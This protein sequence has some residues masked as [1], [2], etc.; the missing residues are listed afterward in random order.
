MAGNNLGLRERFDRLTMPEPNSG[1][2]LW[3]GKT[4]T[5]VRGDNYGMIRDNGVYRQATHVALELA[6]RPLL[7]G[8]I[9]LHHCD[10]GYCVNE[11]HLFGGT[12]RDN[13]LD[14]VRKGRHGS[15][16]KTH[17]PKGH[18]YTPENTR[19]VNDGRRTYRKCRACGR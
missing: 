14:A 13:S 17:C 18:E 5:G 11:V 8:Q 6:N 10:N 1:C 4:G 9:A 12:Y 15:A 2:L 3:L 19:I 16:K 7:P